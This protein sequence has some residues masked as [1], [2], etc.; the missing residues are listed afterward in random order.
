MGIE[1][2]QGQKKLISEIKRFVK[3]ANDPLY[4]YSGPAGS[5][6]TT[7]A[8]E[9]LK[10]SGVGDNYMAVAFVGKAVLVLLMK[11][12]KAVTIH[13]FIYRTYIERDEN[14]KEV[15]RFMLKEKLQPEPRII[16]VDEGSMISDD[17]ME[18]LMS[19]GVQIIMMGDINQLGP[20]FGHC[21]FMLNPNFM[22]TEVMRQALDNPIIWLSQ[23]VLKGREL[24][25][26][27]YGTSKVLTKRPENIHM[28]DNYDIILAGKNATRDTI[29]D[30]FR[31]DIL[32]RKD[33]FPVV[34]DKVICRQNVWDRTIDQFPLTNGTMGMITDID[35]SS[36]TKNK[37]NIDFK[38]DYLRGTFQNI[39]I[40]HKYIQLP[41][42]ERKEMGLTDFVKFE[43]GYC[44]T[45]H[46]SQGSEYNRVL[47]LDE[48]MGDMEHR[49][50]LRYTAITRAVDYVHVVKPTPRKF[51][52]GW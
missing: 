27:N 20:V 12:I 2:N 4:V 22:L 14:G 36:M 35:H 48:P 10:Q 45:V 8:L 29:N 52:K 23:E 47:Y 38:P 49:K 25:P 44:I 40:G 31:F 42:N 43:Y 17:M 5:G 18:D 11:G 41:H 24:V 7:V 30:I 21:S 13:S 50:R 3:K 37:I 46:M 6:K 33:H 28:F 26:G 1:L 32:G 9:A 19:F 16:L 51:T 39:E 15:L 34:G